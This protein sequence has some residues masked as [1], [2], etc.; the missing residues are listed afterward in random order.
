MYRSQQTFFPF[1]E[2]DL[3]TALVPLDGARAS[4]TLPLVEASPPVGTTGE[5][6]SDCCCTQTVK[7]SHSGSQFSVTTLL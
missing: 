5:V 2:V 7:H 6:V 1:L 4:T 3:S